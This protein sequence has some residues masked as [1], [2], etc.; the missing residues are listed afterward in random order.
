RYNG[1]NRH[2][3]ASRE[4]PVMHRNRAT[5]AAILPALLLA[6]LLALLPAALPASPASRSAG[7]VAAATAVARLRCMT[8]PSLLAGG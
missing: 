8:E 5:A 3:P 7:K 6:L 2:P 1:W 4:G